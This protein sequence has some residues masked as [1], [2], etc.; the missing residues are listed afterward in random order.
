MDSYWFCRTPSAWEAQSWRKA[1]FQLHPV[2]I[3]A[4]ASPG[5]AEAPDILPSSPG[6]Q[7]SRVMVEVMVVVQEKVG[8]CSD[9][10]AR[11]GLL[12]TY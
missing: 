12:S 10:A 7:E 6:L 3:C 1:P 8:R 4:G 5:A 11:Q 2:G 9:A